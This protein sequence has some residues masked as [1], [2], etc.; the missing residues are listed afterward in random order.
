MPAEMTMPELLALVR[1]AT[2][3]PWRWAPFPAPS[4]DD[5]GMR[6]VAKVGQNWLIWIPKSRVRDLL[7]RGQANARLI[8]AAPEAA[9]LCK[10]LAT[11]LAALAAAGRKTPIAR[12]GEPGADNFL[13]CS[14]CGAHGQEPCKPG[15]WAHDLEFAC[16]DARALL[17]RIQ[18]PQMEGAG[19]V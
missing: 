2:P 12:I 10:E 8:A 19:D 14:G 6:G 5:H 13:T 1:M 7:G 18:W 16:E 3:G 11:A 9:Q 4:R 17:E 15:C